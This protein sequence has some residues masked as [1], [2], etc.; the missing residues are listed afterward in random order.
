MPSSEDRLAAYIRK[1]GPQAEGWLTDPNGDLVV[2]G[3]EIGL[4]MDY[5]PGSKTGN[6]FDAHRLLHF[7]ETRGHAMQDTVHE[8]LFRKYFA[9]GLS[10]GEHAVLADTAVEANF[11]SKDEAMTFLK[12]EQFAAEVRE[13]LKLTQRE[14]VSGVPFFKFPGN[15]KLSG[16]QEIKKFIVVLE[17]TKTAE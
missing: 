17:A 13:G 7:A 6:T 2:R 12:S 1:F 4:K 9:E 3:R 11:L 8:I 10:P 16:A 15:V 5:M 14:K